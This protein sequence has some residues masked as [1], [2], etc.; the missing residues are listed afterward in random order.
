MLQRG[1]C[2]GVYCT[3]YNLYY[4]SQ[5]SN[6]QTPYFHNI[7]G[8]HLIGTEQYLLVLFLS[9]DDFGFQIILVQKLFLVKVKLEGIA[10]KFTI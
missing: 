5:Q 1:R 2:V 7:Q 10:V 4:L 6:L 8:K 3:W 9:I